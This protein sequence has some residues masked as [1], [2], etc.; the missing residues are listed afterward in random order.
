MGLR[1]LTLHF[2]ENVAYFAK[3]STR[4]TR[5]DVIASSRA[6]PRAF[7][8]GTAPSLKTIH[9]DRL[10]GEDYVV[11]NMA[12]H[13][14]WMRERTHP[15]YV[16]AD[17]GVAEKYEN[18]R[19]GLSARQFFYAQEMRPRLDPA[20][21]AEADPFFFATAR[22]GVAKR[23]LTPEPWV[24]VAGGQTILL[25]ATQIAW[26]LGYREIYV[27]GCDLDYSGPD[28]YAYRTTQVEIDRATRD[29]E[30]MRA[31]TNADFGILRAAIEKRGGVLANAGVGGKL[32]SLPRIPFDT[33]F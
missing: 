13:M 11:C 26:A 12:E 1:T 4:R 24:S 31:R 2:R 17:N 7:V 20:F 14:P 3:H 8:L 25:V 27:I 18:G 29:N 16:A 6:R 21:V 5:F 28:P 30:K 15:Y 33:L 9:L 19:P 32:D 22:G 10:D 23:G